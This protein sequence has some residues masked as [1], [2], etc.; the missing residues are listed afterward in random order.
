MKRIILAALVT[1]CGIDYAGNDDGG[2]RG[3]CG[4]GGTPTVQVTPTIAPSIEV[5][6]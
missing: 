1:G 6:A 2:C 5:W 3:N 4:G